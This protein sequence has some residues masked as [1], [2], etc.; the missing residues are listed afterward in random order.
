MFDWPE[1]SQTSPTAMSS[2]VA[3]EPSAPVTLIESGPPA[4]RA[5]NSACHRPF[6]SAVAVFVSPPR[7][8]LTRSRGFAVPLE[9][10]RFA[11]LDHRMIAELRIEGWGGERARGEQRGKRQ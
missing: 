1:Q 2:A 6:A 10:D 9:Q 8:T 3:A 7:L 11:A 4:A 5:G